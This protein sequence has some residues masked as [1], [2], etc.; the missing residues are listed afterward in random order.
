MPH[1]F[2]T[3]YELSVYSKIPNW[4]MPVIFVQTFLSTYKNNLTITSVIQ[5]ANYKCSGV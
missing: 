2:P 4:L 3:V 1:V 5:E